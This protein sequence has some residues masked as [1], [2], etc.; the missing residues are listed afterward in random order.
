MRGPACDPV[1]VSDAI[2]LHV[3]PD[4]AGASLLLAFEGWNDAGEAATHAARFVQRAIHSVPLADLDYESYVDFTCRRPEV[5]IGSDGG[6]V[7]HWP[8]LAFRY[9][10][11]DTARELVVGIGVEP[12]LRWRAFCDEVADLVDSLGIAQVVFLGAYL[13]DV[14]YS[15][16][17]AV[18]GFASDA[19]RL[20]K[21]GV[22]PSSYAGPTGIIGVLADRL[23]RDGVEMLSLWAGLPHYIDVAPN[24]RG[25][26]ALIQKLAAALDLR[27]DGSPLEGE[28]AEFEGRISELVA[29]DP[30]I[31]D[32][33]RRL[34][35]RE[36]A[37]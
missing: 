11:V 17:V 34:K 8:G 21:L 25:S 9:G 33:V 6:R 32:Y 7:I 12:H 15:R 30:E 19:A 18:T 1:A 3:E 29:G 2:A 5:A 22:V 27:L 24:P 31:G 20:D 26:L 14:V 37:Q 16:P 23:A 10:R 36:F 4:L 35:R 28:A 13:A